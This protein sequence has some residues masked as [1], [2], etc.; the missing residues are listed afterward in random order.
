MPA[1]ERAYIGLGANLGVDLIG[2]LERALAALAAL[3]QTRLVAVSPAYRT[4]PVDAGGPDYLNAVAALDTALA[5]LDLLD[6][7]QAIEQAHGRERPY[8]NAPRTL[9]LDLLLQGECSLQTP[10]LSLPHPR[11]HE[12]AFVLRP[13]LDLAPALQVPG[14]GALRER[15]PAVAGQRLQRLD[16]AL[17]AP[18]AC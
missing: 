13:L 15:L 9:D 3:P 5:P 17:K 14:L 16:Q 12:R 7:L 18:I 4:T 8:R 2:T 6:A 1:A 10:R 11:L